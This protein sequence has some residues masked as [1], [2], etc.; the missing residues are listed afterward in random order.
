M[1]T[2]LINQLMTE[3]NQFIAQDSVND[4]EK[5]WAL[6]QTTDSQLQSVLKQVS[7]TDI[8]VIAYLGQHGPERAKALPGPLNLS[9]ATISRGLTKLARLGLATKYRDLSNN[10]EVLVRLTSLGQ[11]VT[12]LHTKLD[13]A[14]ATQAQAIANDYSDVELKR[15]VSLMRRIREIQI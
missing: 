14:I 7:T 15:F 12:D 10:K 1:T 4:Q 11:A 13:A 9:Q 8:K 6:R 3:L 5:Q 2:S